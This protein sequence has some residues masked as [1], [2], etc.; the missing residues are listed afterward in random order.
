MEDQSN[1]F[2]KVSITG[3]DKELFE[4]LREKLIESILNLNENGNQKIYSSFKTEIVDFFNETLKFGKAYLKKPS[5]ENMKILS[6]VELNYSKKQKE[7]AEA[8]KINAEAQR[9]EFENAMEKIKFQLRL[10]IAVSP[11]EKLDSQDLLF[12]KNIKNWVNKFDTEKALL[13]KN[14]SNN[15]NFEVF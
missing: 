8:R 13:P 10:I 1:K 9:L 15:K 11:P 3:K 7:I 12:I 5:Y 4:T 14:K 2:L 6:E